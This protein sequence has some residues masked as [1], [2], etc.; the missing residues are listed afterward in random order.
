MTC[1]AGK[2]GRLA[3]LTIKPLEVMPSDGAADECDQDCAA[4]VFTD[5]F[6][7]RAAQS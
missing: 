7:L 6:A 2:V 4:R 1:R 5:V 3:E